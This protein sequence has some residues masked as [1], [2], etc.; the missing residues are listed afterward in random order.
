MTAD[1]AKDYVIETI[2]TGD[3]L[4]IARV[5]E[6]YRKAYGKSRSNGKEENIS[7]KTNTD[8]ARYAEEIGLTQKT[9]S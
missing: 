3:K 5:I 4:R 6:K 1:E 9:E 7:T 2:L 8:L